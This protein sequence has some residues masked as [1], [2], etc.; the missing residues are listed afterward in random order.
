GWNHDGPPGKTCASRA[1]F[2]RSSAGLVPTTLHRAER[3]HHAH[4]LPARH[5][6]SHPLSEVRGDEAL[7]GV[8]TSGWVGT[9]GAHTLQ[10]DTDA[11]APGTCDLVAAAEQPGY[12]TATYWGGP[13]RSARLDDEV[14]IEPPA[15]G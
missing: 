2:A 3:G 1:P 15:F 7:S 4:H 13:G 11:A 9:P 14:S 6:P 12:M 5:H 8:G 10:I